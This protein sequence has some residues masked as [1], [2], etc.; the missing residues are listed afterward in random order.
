MIDKKEEIKNGPKPKL[1]EFKY[2]VYY[3]DSR[4]HL[5]L[6]DPLG[7]NRKHNFS[8]NL[9][10]N[11]YFGPPGPPRII[12]KRN[13]I[14]FQKETIVLSTFSKVEGPKPLYCQR[15]PLKMDPNLN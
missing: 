6:G 1:I 15:L 8:N 2:T 9:G 5:I 7:T 13:P 3:P 4:N 14:D 12:F 11:N 10:G